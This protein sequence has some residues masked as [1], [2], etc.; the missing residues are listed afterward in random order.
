MRSVAESSQLLRV[1]N[2]AS[3]LS[4]RSVNLAL[5]DPWSNEMTL[6]LC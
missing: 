3:K 2:R 6:F 1:V 4:K 5:N